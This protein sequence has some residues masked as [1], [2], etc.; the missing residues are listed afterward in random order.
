MEKSI[1]FVYIR[2]P[3]KTNLNDELQWFGASLGLFQL[4]DKNSSCFR[5]F[6]ELLKSAKAHQGLSSDE[7]AYKLDLARSTVVH[8]LTKLM[9]EGIVIHHNK[10]Y[11]LRT[12]NLEELMNEIRKDYVNIINDLREIAK[13]IDDKLNF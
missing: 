5:V 13:D 8:H 2:K 6:I 3:S 9:Y 7:L 4:R 11:I 12:S 1:T 10:Q